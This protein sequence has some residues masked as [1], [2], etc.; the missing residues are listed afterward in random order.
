[1]ALV[2][3]GK[4]IQFSGIL[5]E[6]FCTECAICSSFPKASLL[7]WWKTAEG[8]D[9]LKCRQHLWAVTLGRS[10]LCYGSSLWKR[11]PCFYPSHQLRGS[12]RFTAQAREHPA[13]CHSPW[14]LAVPVALG[15]IRTISYSPALCSDTQ[16]LRFP[17]QHTG[18]NSEDSK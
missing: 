16:A 15:A 1:M 7:S 17:H 5:Y 11:K 3:T 18:A 4:G 9:V 12:L 8:W 14:C 2:T 13:S 10:A 6:N